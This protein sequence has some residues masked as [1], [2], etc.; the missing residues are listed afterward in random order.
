MP[1]VSRPTTSPATLRSTRTS[2]TANVATHVLPLR[3]NICPLPRC[4][5]PVHRRPETVSVQL[6]GV[7]LHALTR[8]RADHRPAFRVHVEHQRLGFLL[9]VAE[10]L[11]KNPGHVRHEVD[12]I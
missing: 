11:L 2:S 10:E 9:R 7:H 4:S 5:V 8:T 12:R 3:R 6:I 1:S